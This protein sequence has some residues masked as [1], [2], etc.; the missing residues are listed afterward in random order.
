[1]R[2]GLDS[3]LKREGGRSI[4]LDSTEL[5]GRIKERLKVDRQ[6]SM[7]VRNGDGKGNSRMGGKV[8]ATLETD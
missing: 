3:R 1:M 7:A 4:Q 8:E 5:G 2:F 6:G